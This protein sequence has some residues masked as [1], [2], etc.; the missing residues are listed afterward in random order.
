MDVIAAAVHAIY[1]SPLATQVRE[2]EWTFPITQTV[3]ILGLLIFFGSIAILDLK[4][5]GVI[6]KSTPAAEISRGLLPLAWAAFIA[7]ALS[8]SIMLAAQLEKIY[9]NR[10]LLTKFALIV[11][12]GINILIFHLTIGGSIDDWGRDGP[13]ATPLAARIAGGLS[14]SLWAAVVVMGRF[15]AYFGDTGVAA[16]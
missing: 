13:R 15:I 10:F 7:L 6:L 1:E 16:P 8:G 9:T 12:A 11:A 2:S 14:L 5:L 4:F 3:H